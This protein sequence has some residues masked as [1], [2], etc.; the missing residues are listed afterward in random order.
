MVHRSLSDLCIAGPEVERKNLVVHSRTS[1]A[2][3]GK[4]RAQFGVYV[5]RDIEAVAGVSL[6]MSHAGLHGRE[7]GH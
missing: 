1:L 4:H 2:S 3:K 6:Q 5:G 7:H